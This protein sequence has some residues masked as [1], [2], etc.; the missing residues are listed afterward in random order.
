MTIGIATVTRPRRFAPLRSTSRDAIAPP[1][2]TPY[3]TASI[4]E[5]RFVTVLMKLAEKSWLLSIEAKHHATD[6]R[7]RNWKFPKILFADT[8]EIPMSMYNF[9]VEL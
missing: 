7:F 2:T 1:K 8:A 4:N 5:K 9:V 6:H 3:Q